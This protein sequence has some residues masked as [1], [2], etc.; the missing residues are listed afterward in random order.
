MLKNYFPPSLSFL[1]DFNQNRTH[2]EFARLIRDFGAQFSSFG[3][4]AR[5]A[6]QLPGAYNHGHKEGWCHTDDMRDPAQFLDHGRNYE[7]NIYSNR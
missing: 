6:G 1:P 7:M 3:V 4:V 2:V 5:W